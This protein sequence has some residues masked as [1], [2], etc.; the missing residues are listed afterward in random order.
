MTV[1]EPSRYGCVMQGKVRNI[2]GISLLPFCTGLTTSR[3]VTTKSRVELAGL[4]DL[5]SSST[6]HGIDTVCACRPCRAIPDLICCTAGT[7]VR[8]N[9]LA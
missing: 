4:G 7:I 8:R 2:G 1:G 6:L 3:S 9:Q 5:R